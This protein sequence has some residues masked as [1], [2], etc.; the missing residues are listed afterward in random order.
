MGLWTL[1]AFRLLTGVGAAMVPPNIFAVIADVFPPGR[2][3]PLAG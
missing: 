1:L 2:G 3:K